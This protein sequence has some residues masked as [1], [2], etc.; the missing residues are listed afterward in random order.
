L[1]G[2]NRR[3]HRAKHKKNVCQEPVHSAYDLCIL[4]KHEF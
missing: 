4:S 3:T 1:S 2:D